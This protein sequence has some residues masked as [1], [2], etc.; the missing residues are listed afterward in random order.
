VLT[1]KKEKLTGREY[2]QRRVRKKV[3]G[4]AQKPRLCV[5]RSARHI[6]VQAIDDISGHTLAQASTLDKDFQRPADAKGKI[7]DAAAVG[8]LIAKRLIL[9]DL[10]KV[11]FDRNGFL[12]HGRVKAVAEGARK[13]GLVF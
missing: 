12:Y 10:K 7:V 5:F 11:V 9:Q 2:R 13:A 3:Q 6:Y 4:T 8:E 1:Y